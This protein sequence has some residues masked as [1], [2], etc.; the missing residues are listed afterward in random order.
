MSGKTYTPACEEVCGA[1]GYL[2]KGYITLHIICR[3]LNV[4]AV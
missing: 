1:D 4:Y 2:P 3:G